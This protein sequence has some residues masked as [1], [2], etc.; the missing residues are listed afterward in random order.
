MI[1]GRWEL[2]P[3]RHGL[4]TR[5]CVRVKAGLSL[6]LNLPKFS[7]YEGKKDMLTGFGEVSDGVRE[8]HGMSG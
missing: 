3:L 5:S 6:T 2:L 1:P 8:R 7:E 4:V